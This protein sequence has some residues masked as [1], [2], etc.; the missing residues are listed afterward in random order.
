MNE[1]HDISGSQWT[2]WVAACQ[3]AVNAIRA[4]GATSQYIVLPGNFWTHP[5]TWASGENNDMLSITDP[6][7]GDASLLL[8][9]AHKY[10]DSDGSGTSTTCTTNAVSTFQSFVSFLRSKGR[11]ALLTEF[12]G[13]NNAGC[14]SYISQALS[15][16]SDNSDVV[17]GFTA[18]SAGAFDNTYELNLGP[19]ADG[20]DQYLWA[21]AIKAYLPGNNGGPTTTSTSIT[22]SATSSVKPSTTSVAP[23]STSSAPATTSSAP[24]ASC[25][26]VAKWGQCGGIGYTG[27]KVCV[28]G[29]TCTYNNDWYSQCL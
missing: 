4:A 19:N 20:S 13:G 3:L 24:P 11:Q 26:P 17:L 5:E 12:G 28:A 25:T 14:A 10:F 29:S 9:D 22:P 21:N 8:L 27:C 7:T 16:L 2:N 23:S 18:W 15:Y 1:P 6:A